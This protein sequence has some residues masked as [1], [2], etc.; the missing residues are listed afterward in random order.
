MIPVLLLAALLDA[1]SAAPA[2]GEVR[3]AG[4]TV[5]GGVRVEME[6]RLAMASPAEAPH[7]RR[8][9]GE[10]T[11]DPR[12]SAAAVAI[13]GGRFVPPYARDGA[14]VAVD[15]FRLDRTPVTVGE[16]LAFVAD[17]PEWRRSRVPALFADARYLAGWAGDLEPGP[18]AATGEALRRPVT[19]VSWFAARAYC[20]AAGG[21]LPTTHEW[22]F[23]ARASRTRTDAFRD[24]AFNRELLAL[25]Q[26][27]SG[28]DALPT[29]G[30]T[31]TDARGV[32]DLH[33]VVWE[34]TDDFNNTMLTGAGRDD[35]G[36]D[37]GLFCAA[38]SVD[39]SDRSDYVAFLRYG[40][41]AGLE[42]TDVGPQLGFRCAWD[43][44]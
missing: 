40:F 24:P 30:R 7:L 36:I 25:Q 33:G 4:D 41:R 21:R 37:R 15:P 22:E 5:G 13:S 2:A 43:M 31:W 44:P 32:H 19:G 34:W 12:G 1:S 14:E 11:E 27:R 8:G 35:Q 16:Y 20:S 10:G 17:H 39:A 9:W 42:G 29:V 26:A 23:A 3:A 28:R 18:G 6:A 38:G